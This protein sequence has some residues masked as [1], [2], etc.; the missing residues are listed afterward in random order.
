MMEIVG[1]KQKVDDNINKL[2][3][4]FVGI[5]PRK[6]IE[7]I[8]YLIKDYQF[9]L[10]EFKVDKDYVIEHY[11]DIGYMLFYKH[12]SSYFKNCRRCHKMKRERGN[13]GVYCRK[14]ENSD[15]C[16]SCDKVVTTNKDLYVLL[17]TDDVVCWECV[18]ADQEDDIPLYNIALLNVI[19]GETGVADI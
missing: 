15:K 5:K 12:V 3:A 10:W 9:V 11:N 16:T 18:K 13:N 6:F 7:E 1:L 14:C 19:N 8:D 17:P 2:I 4:K